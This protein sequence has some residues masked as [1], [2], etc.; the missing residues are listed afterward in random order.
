MRSAAHYEAWQCVF[1]SPDKWEPASASRLN[2]RATIKATITW[3]ALT[4]SPR[5]FER[6]QLH[7]PFMGEIPPRK[8]MRMQGIHFCLLYFKKFKVVMITE[9]LGMRGR[10]ISR[11]RQPSVTTQLWL[12]APRLLLSPFVARAG[13]SG[14]SPG[15]RSA[16]TAGHWCLLP[17]AA[18]VPRPGGAEQ[19]PLVR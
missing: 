16:W 10:G 4:C 18:P 12:Q 5:L 3:R 6:G 14:P 15:G 11:G 2:P 8:M 9:D 19:L 17:T 1:L 13:T 7:L